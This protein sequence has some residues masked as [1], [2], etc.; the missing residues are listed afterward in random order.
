[1]AVNQRDCQVGYLLGIVM[2]TEDELRE[3]LEMTKD[4]HIEHPLHSDGPHRY[5]GAQLAAALLVA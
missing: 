2:A 5:L 3:G 1:M 4:S